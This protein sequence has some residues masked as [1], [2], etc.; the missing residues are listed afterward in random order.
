MLHAG[1]FGIGVTIEAV[2]EFLLD[3]VTDRPSLVVL[4]S[5]SSFVD[6]MAVDAADSFGMASLREVTRW[7]IGLSKLTF[8][9]IAFRMLS[10]L[11]KEGRAKGRALDH[12]CDFALAMESSDEPGEVHVK[13]LRTTKNWH[14]PIG[15]LG[16]FA[17]HWE[18]GRLARIAEDGD[19]GENRDW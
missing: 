13:A 5:V 3:R 14:G 17:L 8:G 16:N 19:Y 11:N 6:N 1:S 10:E 9:Q 4:D 2:V 12:R 15:P 7:A 18:L